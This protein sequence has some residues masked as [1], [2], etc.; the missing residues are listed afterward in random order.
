[1]QA[2]LVFLI[3]AFAFFPQVASA[4][5]SLSEGFS[6]PLPILLIGYFAAGLLLSL[7]P[8]NLPMVPILSSVIAGSNASPSRGLFLSAVYVF[9]MSLTYSV[10][11]V[12][13]STLGLS[14]QGFIQSPVV[15]SAFSALFALLGLAMMGVFNL[16]VPGFISDKLAT[17][18]QRQTGGNVGGVFTLGVLSALIVGP[19]MT[20]PL[21]GALVFIADSGSWVIGGASLFVMGLGIGVPLLLIGYFGSK[22]LPKPGLWM[23]RVNVLFGFIM[24]A[25]AV[26]FLDRL[27][28][29][30]IAL[31][32]YSFV[33]LGFS[34]YC[35]REFAKTHVVMSK[36]MVALASLF[37]TYASFNLP[38]TLN[39]QAGRSF[40][41]QFQT[42]NSVDEYEHVLQQVRTKKKWAIVDFYADWCVSCKAFERNTLSRSDVQHELSSFMLIKADVTDNTRKHQDLMRSLK[43]LGPPTILLISPDGVEI[44]ELR[45]VGDV[46]AEAFLKLLR[47]VQSDV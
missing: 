47:S 36:L 16:Q 40:S 1:M 28:N 24:L 44:K 15:L 35:Y 3:I 31:L 20:A 13:I 26:Y 42:I 22:L 38:S 4:Q 2:W 37:V 45:I 25:L 8:C 6:S 12:V 32:L 23:N 18:S 11:G 43:V 34:I 29:D 19:C 10:A 9:S 30:G 7:T 5:V 39:E 17:V 41:E 33:S 14:M 21:A 46:S 27:I